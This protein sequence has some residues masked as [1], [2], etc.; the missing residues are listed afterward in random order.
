MPSSLH[1]SL[2][3]D[4]VNCVPLSVIILLGTPNLTT[5]S[6][7]NSFALATVIV[8]T[9]LASIHLVNLS[10]ATKRCVKP[11]GTLCRGLTML[12]PQ[13]ANNHVIGI[14]CNS[15]AGTCICQA[16]Y[17]HPSHLRMISSASVIE[18]AR[19]NLA[20]KPCGPMFLMRHD[21]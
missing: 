3:S 16:K 19:R 4:P 20:D 9:G 10:M 12:R 1:Q 2:N 17:W 13:T 21:F 18:L 6:W 5:M 15:C 8:A 7:K 11:P 14:V